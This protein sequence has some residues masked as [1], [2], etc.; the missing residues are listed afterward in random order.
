MVTFLGQI[1]ANTQIHLVHKI[2]IV[3]DTYD[4][5]DTYSQK[6]W[7][8]FWGEFW[9]IH[10]YIHDPYDTYDTYKTCCTYDRYG[11]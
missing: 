9:Q 5:H 4:T 7:S 3:H 2:H 1:W 11:T 10:T 8:H 6:S